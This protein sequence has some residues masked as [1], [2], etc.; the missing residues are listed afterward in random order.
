MISKDNFTVQ[1]AQPED[2]EWVFNLAVQNSRANVADRSQGFVQGSAGNSKAYERWM[3]S[4]SLFILKDLDLGEN[5]GFVVVQMDNSKQMQG[6]PILQYL[7]SHEQSLSYEDVPLTE[8]P[9][10]MYG[11]VLIAAQYRGQGLARRLMD[12][13][14]DAAREKGY[15]LLIAFIDF[16]N[17]KSMAVHQALGMKVIE[18][19]HLPE[20]IYYL[21]GR[22][23]VS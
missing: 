16:E 6:P 11:P 8:I 4:G 22:S 17:K 20:G 19:V 12:F 21:M 23:T 10:T 7:F 15:R 9:W 5:A 13:A 18:E 2:I 3:Q 14:V 1:P